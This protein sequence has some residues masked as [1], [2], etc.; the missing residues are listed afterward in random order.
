MKRKMFKFFATLLALTCT[1]MALV[2]CGGNSTSSQGSS[3]SE[4]TSNVNLTILKEEDASMIN[5]YSL[6]AVDPAAK[7]ISSVD[8]TELPAG[9]VDINAAGADALIKWLSSQAGRNLISAYGYEEYNE[10]LFYLLDTA[11]TYSGTIAQATL[12]TK[13]IRLSTTTSVKDSGLL[14]YLLPQF[15]TQYGY[16]VEVASAGTGK[17]IAAAT[18]GN[19]DLILVHAKSQEETFITDGYARVVDG[20][21][22][23]RLAFMYNYFVL[24]GPKNDPAKVKEA[25][26]VKA[27]FAAIANGQY[28]F[29]SRGD[30]SGT[31]TKE[32]SLW[33]SSLAITTEAD[34]I[35][36]YSWYT[37]S[38]AGMGACLSMAN[39]QAAYILSDKATFLTFAKNNGIVAA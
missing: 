39:E 25:A 27:A 10:H 26:D 17:A 21:T 5:T 24:C 22:S 36:D 7:F 16:Q 11:Q 6:I 34:S 29:I 33:D 28:K 19:A 3:T 20:F 9:A 35:K 18:Y 1:S 32:I 15:E 14:A 12:D 30:K 31:H 23:E 37:F 38:N 4:P 8:G 2:G 13:T